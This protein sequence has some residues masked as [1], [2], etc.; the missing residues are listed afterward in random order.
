[1][2]KIDSKTQQIWDKAEKCNCGKIGCLP[3]NHRLCAI[4]HKKMLYGSYYGEETQRNSR[5]AWDV[6]HKQSKFNNG[7]DESSNLRAVHVSCNRE[8]G[9]K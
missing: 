4:C 6:D 8:K 3:Q 2:A 5:Y 9:S 1:M 7:K